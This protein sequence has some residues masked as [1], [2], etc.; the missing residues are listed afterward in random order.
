MASPE[1]LKSTA[2]TGYDAVPPTKPTA[3]FGGAS[4][5][6]EVSGYVTTSAGTTTGS[7]FQLIRLKSNVCLKELWFES[8]AD[9]GDPA[10]KLGLY[11][12]DAPV[13][14]IMDGT[15][16]LLAGTVLDDDLFNTDIDNTSAIVPTN[17]INSAGDFSIV[18]RTTQP[19]WQA[20]GLTTDPGGYFDVV[21]V[22]T[23]TNTNGALLGVSARFTV[24]M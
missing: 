3:G 5:L 7:T 15:P 20:A 9:G 11:Y 12:S 16:P 14:G 4:P 21:L 8:A 19:L 1:H 2:I 10:Y 17:Y 22:G 18:V 6:I 23:A 13:G 24:P